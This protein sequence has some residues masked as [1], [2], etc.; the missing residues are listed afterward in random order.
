MATQQGGAPSG[1]VETTQEE[2]KELVS[3]AQQQVQEKT[4][5]LRD[6]AGTRLREQVDQRSTQAGEQVQAVGQAMKQTS[7]Q[8]RS[9][10]KETPARAVEQAAQKVDDLGGYLRSAD[11][12]RILHDVER[13]ARRRPW[14][15]AA[16][17]AALGFVAS[18]FLKASSERRYEGDGHAGSFAR[19]ELP[20]GARR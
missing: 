4:H 20:A 13:F 9:E 17:G 12:D 3:Q 16:T 15:T 8:L 7:E 11:A 2:G 1:A 19:P 14:L 18:R 6:E 10:G 5:E